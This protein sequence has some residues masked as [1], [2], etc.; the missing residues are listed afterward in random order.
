[1]KRQPPPNERSNRDDRG[2]A[3]ARPGRPRRTGEGSESA[4]ASL[5]TMERDRAR[6]V[7]AEDERPTEP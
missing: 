3:P 4:L 5:R 2:N 7:P 6:T 1:M